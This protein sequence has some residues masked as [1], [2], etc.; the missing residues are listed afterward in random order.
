MKKLFSIILTFMLCLS[1]MFCLP[2]AASN[3]E[4]NLDAIK[5][6]IDLGHWT[7]AEPYAVNHV[8]GIC[9][10]DAGEYMYVSFTNLLAKI[11][12]KTGETVAT[13][14]G[15]K[16]G[17]HNN[18]G[19]HIGDLAYH[20]GKVYSPMGYTDA[21]SW[22]IAVI[23]TEKLT[24]MD[25]LY[26]APGL[27]SALYLPQVKADY[28]NELLAG[29]HVYENSMGHRYGSVGIEGIA[30]GKMP[31]GGYDKNCDGTV[32]VSTGD[33]EFLFVGY[34]PANNAKRYDNENNILLVFDFD[35][36]TDENLRPFNEA[37]FGRAYTEAESFYYNHKIFTYLGNHHYGVQQLEADPVTR[38]LLIE[39]YRQSDGTE[40]PHYTRYVLDGSKPL[41]MDEVEV[42]QS[43]TGDKDKFISQ[44][45]AFATAALY[46]D[47]EDA[48]EDGD[49]S[50]RETGWHAPLKCIC[51]DGKTMNDHVEMTYGA[52]GHPVKIC[53]KSCQ[54]ETGLAALGN[55]YFYGAK[56]TCDFINGV[57]HY[58]GVAKLYKLN[59]ETYTYESVNHYPYLFEDFEYSLKDGTGALG[60]NHSMKYRVTGSYDDVSFVIAKAPKA[61]ED[62]NFSAWVKI[63]NT[64]LKDDKV[65]FLLWGMGRAYRTSEDTSLPETIEI[66]SY[67]SIDATSCGIKKGEWT[68]VTATKKNWDGKLRGVIPAGYNG[69]TADTRG[70]MDAIDVVRAT[71]RLNGPSSAADSVGVVEHSFDDFAFYASSAADVSAENDGNLF[72]GSAMDTKADISQWSGNSISLV[73]EK[74][75]DG[76]DGYMRFGT[77]SKA[78]SKELKPNVTLKANRLYKIS[79]WARIEDVPEGV[80]AKG[81]LW[82]LQYQAN[83]IPDTN[84]YN[85]KY[86]G[87]VMPEIL[88]SEWQKVE[89]YYLREFKTFAEETKEL[90]FRF[91]QGSD[92][93]NQNTPDN[94]MVLNIDDFRMMDLGT[95][96]NGDASLGSESIYQQKGGVRNAVLTEKKVLGWTENGA[97]AETDN[98]TLKF[99]ATKDGGNAYQGINMDNG[100]T[101]K[102]SF[103]A[104]TN[105]AAEKPLAVVLDRTV[106]SSGGDKEAYDVPDYQ[107]LTGTNGDWK[108]TD[109]WQTFACYVSNEFPLKDGMTAQ[110]GIVPRTPFM[111]FEVDG[112]KA[113]T[114]IYVD[115]ITMEKASVYP[116]VLSP[117]VFGEKAPGKTLTFDYSYGSGAGAAEKCVVIRPWLK[118]GENKVSLG[119]L[120]RGDSIVLPDSVAGKELVVEFLPVDENDTMGRSVYVTVEDAENWG[121]I[122]YNKDSKIAEVYYSEDV[123]AEVIF[124]SYKDEQLLDVKIVPVTVTADTISTA[125][126]S[127]LVT[128]G[129]DII[130]V[131]AWNSASGA[132]PLCENLEIE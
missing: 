95:V 20:N 42:G 38:D 45:D 118:A 16:T 85:E 87:I 24:E 96:A 44:A 63:D 115:D 130:K 28:V 23:D 10:D 43:V 66:A 32:D 93:T 17:T 88:S 51:G 131:M 129:A 112:N 100:G 122:S 119:T 69:M 30:V 55:D 105:S 121:K 60:S 113:G 94:T 4:S 46:T 31:G 19:G 25:M 34:N 2:T 62:L 82:M 132:I 102:L 65:T 99:T 70:W 3:T 71:I 80:D 21:E 14:Y 11:D 26:T 114:E 77:T 8:Q 128:N 81:G 97:T 104:K 13:M 127:A 101:Y 5:T 83:R 91:Y 111:Y 33:E 29:E 49:V 15:L 57:R 64:T 56:N 98:G 117:K 50:E 18:G 27:M 6:E 106:P 109:E 72:S 75:P 86:P 47:Y 90:V 39:S 110:A 41:Y 73:Q 92:T 52:T 48:D 74:A 68:Y 58:G 79:F 123:T 40:F 76:S 103:R 84:G 7:S 125:D 78:S 116:E 89:F 53:G 67:Y 126:G 124:A 37:D 35:D 54:F 59:R 61:G 36:I 107:R 12:I 1:V 22:F 9:V 120:Y 108:V